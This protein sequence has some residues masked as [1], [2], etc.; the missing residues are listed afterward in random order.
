MFGNNVILIKFNNITILYVYKISKKMVNFLK[1]TNFI[2]FCHNL[3]INCL[4]KV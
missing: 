2:F 1:I 3:D 4:I